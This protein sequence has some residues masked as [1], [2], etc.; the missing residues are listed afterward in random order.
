MKSGHRWGPGS[1]RPLSHEVLANGDIPFPK[2]RVVDNDGL[3]GDFQLGEARALAAQRGT[4]LVVLSG[5]VRPPLCKLVRLDV[6]VEELEQKKE[7]L[8]GRLKQQLLKEFSFDPALKVKGMRFTA[9]VDEHDFERKVNHI[10]SFIEK[11]HRVEARV[12]QG[13]MLAED[14]LD[15][16]MRI[17][18]ELRDIAKPENFEESI[19]E[20][21]GAANVPKS[22]R[23]ARK[24]PPEEIRLRLWPCTPAQAAAFTLPA[25]VLGPR[26]R[27]GPRIAGIDDGEVPE[28]AWKLN[29]KPKRDKPSKASLLRM[30]DE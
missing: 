16:A 6:Y 3:V 23:R 1:A 26:R 7:A 20:F 21:R 19:R 27:R 11:G 18:A 5:T 4:D 17:C 10:R 15:L 8:S 14:V 2:V 25:N 13:R 22:L 29:R 12:L 28:D 9:M 24:A 30:F